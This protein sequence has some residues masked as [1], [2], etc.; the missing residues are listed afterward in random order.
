MGIQLFNENGQNDTHVKLIEMMNSIKKVIVDT[1]AT[2]PVPFIKQVKPASDSIEMFKSKISAMIPD[3]YKYPNRDI[4][5]TKIPDLEST[6]YT[7]Y[8]KAIN[9]P[10]NK[11]DALTKIAANPLLSDDSVDKL[12]IKSIN[13]KFFDMSQHSYSIVDK[14][15]RKMPYKQVPA[16]NALFESVL[17]HGMDIMNMT[18]KIEG[19]FNGQQNSFQ[20][21]L[22]EVFFKPKD[23]QTNFIT[24]MF[25]NDSS[26]SEEDDY[27]EI[28]N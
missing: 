2:N 21:R 10:S 25:L 4:D 1:I 20:T 16:V 23:Q 15:R 7:V 24:P 26:E 11:E 27:D 9:Y 22:L 3:L 19:I 28:N 5:G 12:L 8:I 14:K 13:T 6:N 18:F 17:G